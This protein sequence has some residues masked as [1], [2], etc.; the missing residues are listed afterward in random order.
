MRSCSRRS[1]LEAL[2]CLV[3]GGARLGVVPLAAV[4]RAEVREHAAGTM[5]VAEI[6]QERD[7][8]LVG[9]ERTGVVADPR[10]GEAEPVQGQRRA[11]GVAEFPE[12]RERLLAQLD[13]LARAA[14]PTAAPLPARSAASPPGGPQRAGPPAER[15]AHAARAVRATRPRRRPHPRPQAHAGSRSPPPLSQPSRG[16]PRLRACRPSRSGR[17]ALGSAAGRTAQLAARPARAGLERGRDRPPLQAD[18]RD[19]E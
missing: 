11:V 8:R 10:L 17:C 15:R 14:P 4:E 6:R 3:P 1:R 13:R 7:R 9:V 16:V 12:D 19:E 5:A 2:E 18:D